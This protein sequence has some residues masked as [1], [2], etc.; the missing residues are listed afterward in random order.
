MNKEEFLICRTC[1]EEF[2]TK[3][4]YHSKKGYFDQCG[5]CSVDVETVKGALQYTADGDVV[6]VT[7]VSNAVFEKLLAVEAET[8]G[9]LSGG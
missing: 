8:N 5:D 1:S 7:V 4:P 2:D 6:G 3:L 9:I